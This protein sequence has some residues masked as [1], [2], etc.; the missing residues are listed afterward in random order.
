[1][2]V[3][4][5]FLLERVKPESVGDSVEFLYRNLATLGA[6]R[7]PV[8]FQLPPNMKKDVERL[9]GFLDRLPKSPRFAVEFRHESWF[10]D[11]VTRAL[12]EHDVAM[13]GIEQEDFNGARTPLLL[14]A[15]PGTN[16]GS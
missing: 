3:S 1:M 14:L 6:K 16:P 12:R 10:D 2:R 9:H 8:L 7:G 13:V 4:T 11:D 15:A 5:L